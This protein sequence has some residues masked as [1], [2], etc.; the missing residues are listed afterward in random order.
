M[1]ERFT[2]AHSDAW[3]KFSYLSFAVAF[4]MTAAGIVIAPIGLALKGFLGMAMLMLIQTTV[5][6]SKTI[7][8]NHEAD[9]LMTRIDDAQTEKLLRE[10]K[11][12][13]A[14]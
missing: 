9:K 2:N 13:E 14:A 3:V 8:D 10:V 5:N 6:L 7:R 11:V 1:S 4:G 12:G